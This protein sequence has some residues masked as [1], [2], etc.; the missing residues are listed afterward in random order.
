MRDVK[1]QRIYAGTYA[2][3]T[4]AVKYLGYPRTAGKTGRAKSV[5][6]HETWPLFHI[7]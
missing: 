2:L 6:G 7:L 5:G 1:R 3:W 4:W